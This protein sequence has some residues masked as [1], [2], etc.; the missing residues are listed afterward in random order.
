MNHTPSDRN[1]IAVTAFYALSLPSYDMPFHAH[2]S[3]EIMYVT[4]G[5]CTVCVDQTEYHLGK[6]EFIFLEENVLH[7]LYIPEGKP[8]SLLN[9]E[10]RCQCAPTGIDL[11]EPLRESAE[12]SRFW[13][14]HTDCEFG[15][16]S[17]HLGYALKD[18]INSLENKLPP[19]GRTHG[20]D[21]DEDPSRDYL[22]RLLFFRVMLELSH[23]LLKTGKTAGMGYLRKACAY[24]S[25]HLTDEL[26][27]SDLAG[28]AGINK[29]YLQLLFSRY[30]GCSITEYINHRRM[31]QAEFLLVNSSLSVTDIAFQTGYNSRQYFGAVFEK[32]YKISPRTYRQLHG[33]TLT[34]TTD[35][36]QYCL[37]PDGGWQIEPL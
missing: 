16:D 1:Y 5:C 8:C 2:A 7:R 26:R 31:E 9:L 15:G 32:Y 14:T 12:F 19:S 20:P 10:F 33:K 25:S 28:E 13:T 34:P 11:G 37:G 23:C 18:L 24:I 30:L 17:S 36:G 6:H 3:C 29:S 21:A 27:V 35:A 4:K 22:V